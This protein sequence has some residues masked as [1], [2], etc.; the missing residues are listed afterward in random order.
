MPNLSICVCVCLVYLVQHQVI[1]STHTVASRSSAWC[2][3]VLEEFR[4]QPRTRVMTRRAARDMMHT[5]TR[6]QRCTRLC[7]RNII[8]AGILAAPTG[9]YRD[10][11]RVRTFATRYTA[12]PRDA[13]AD[14]PSADVLAKQV[15]YYYFLL[16][17]RAAHQN[18]AH[19]CAG[20]TS[21][22]GG[23]DRVR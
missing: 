19:H 15:D 11:V 6:T 3:R 23:G 2:A 8:W 12:N 4:S 5:H 7:D 10:R 16:R 13:P 20:R 17:T 18:I 14:Q 1:T 9:E 21:H 22:I